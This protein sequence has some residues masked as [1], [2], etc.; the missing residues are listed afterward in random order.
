MTNSKCGRGCKYIEI[1]IQF[2]YRASVSPFFGPL[3][4]APYAM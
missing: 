2:Q 4:R 3:S 1:E